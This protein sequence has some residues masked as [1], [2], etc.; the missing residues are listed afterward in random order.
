CASRGALNPGPHSPILLA[1]WGDERDEQDIGSDG[2]GICGGC[3]ARAVAD[4]IARRDRGGGCVAASAA[5]GTFDLGAGPSRERVEG[6]RAA[7][8]DGPSRGSDGRTRLAAGVGHERDCVAARTGIAGRKPGAAGGIRGGSDGR[9]TGRNAARL[10]THAVRDAARRGA[11]RS[12]SCGADRR[13][14]EGAGM[15]GAAESADIGRGGVAP[16]AGGATIREAEARDSRAM[17][18]LAGELGYASS[19]EDVERRLAA[20]R[21]R[22]IMAR[23]WL[24]VFV[25]RTIEAEPRAEISG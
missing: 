10:R 18:G 23:L 16:R 6:N 9:T 22:P 15:S 20:M 14:E 8:A 1:G 5:A 2:A 24:G 25:A 17:A 21:G 11:A 4:A 13:A 12:V 19:A 3:V 7:P